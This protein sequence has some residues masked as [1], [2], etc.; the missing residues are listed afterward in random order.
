MKKKSEIVTFKV[1]GALLEA[2]KGVQNRSDFIR[3]ALMAALD[4]SCPVCKGTGLITPCQRRHWRKFAEHH[5]LEECPECDT[6]HLVC[7]K[8]DEEPA[9]LP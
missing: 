5:H 8:S 4:G 2:L 3:S 1:D 6:V 9:E 7:E